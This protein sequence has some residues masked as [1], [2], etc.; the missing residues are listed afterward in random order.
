MAQH[1]KEIAEAKPFKF[2][3]KYTRN[4]LGMVVVGILMMLGGY[5]LTK[6]GG[7]HGDHGDHGATEHQEGDH[8]EGGDHH[9]AGGDHH[10]GNGAHGD[11][12]S[13]NGSV[14]HFA[15]ESHGDDH[16]DEHGESLHGPSDHKEN[17][18]WRRA[19]VHPEQMNLVDDE[20]N[21][22]LLNGKPV[23][24]GA[25]HHPSDASKL[26][27]SLLGGAFWWLCIALFGVFFIAVGYMANAGWYVTIKR[28]LEPYYRFLPVGGLVML[29]VFFGLG[30]YVWDWQYYALNKMDGDTQVLFD[31]LVDHKSPFL[32]VTFILATG[33]L[34][35][36]IW[37]MFGHM[38]RKNSLAE[39]MEGGLK[40]HKKSVRLSAMFLPIFALGFSLLCF[41]WIMSLEPHWFSTIYAVYCFA[42]LFV[43]GA[44]IT[45]MIAIH[46]Y[47]KGHLPELSGDHMHDLGKF[48]FAF[49]I[50]WAYIWVSQFL[51]IW[52]A[53][54]PEETIYYNARFENYYFLFA[55]NFAINFIF[56][57]LALMMRNSKRKIM[58]LR[59]VGRVMLVGRFFDV[60]LLIAP[61]A[62]GAAWGIGDIVMMA[63]S[64][65]MMGG[66]FLYIVFKGFEQTK[67]VPKNHPYYKESVH[68]STGV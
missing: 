47:E 56:P 59:S 50:F 51:L 16:G 30:G 11:A 28:I 63:G 21:T 55:A 20:G 40:Y 34:I 13:D 14:L 68:H 36:G 19:Y 38:L 22:V 4:F 23:H 27:A 33:L 35:V 43:S 15:S 18:T 44:T 46:L 10:E 66:I 62:L 2:T 65:V 52:Y 58:S 25:H 49:S 60:F 5:G 31:T 17:G 3:G 42:G 37:T 1:Q 53:N 54:I 6:V 32:N 9:D 48:M 26:G 67:M 24:D 8:N 12:H 61:G 7:D 29:G 64:F 45:S 57:F 39:E 41:A